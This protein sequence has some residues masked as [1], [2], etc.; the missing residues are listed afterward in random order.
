MQGGI[1][2]TLEGKGGRAGWS[3][4]FV[5]DFVSAIML[6]VLQSATVRQ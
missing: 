3:W 2:Q 4:L 5:I 6:L 1:I